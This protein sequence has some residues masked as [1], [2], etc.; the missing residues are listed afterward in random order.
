VPFFQH[1]DDTIDKFQYVWKFCNIFQLYYSFT[2][3]DHRPKFQYVQNDPKIVHHAKISTLVTFY[4]EQQY[5]RKHASKVATPFIV[6]NASEDQ[7][8]RN[9]TTKEIVQL[10]RNPSNK[11]LELRGADH[12]DITYEEDNAEQTI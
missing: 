9:S 11:I 4:D 3:S 12:T 6:V 10:V 8:S 7:T 5:A 2:L 1:K